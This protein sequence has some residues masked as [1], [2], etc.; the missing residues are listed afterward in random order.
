VWAGNFRQAAIA[1][2]HTKP[3]FP[4]L[5]STVNIETVNR[6]RIHKA[7]SGRQGHWE[8]RLRRGLRA[9]LV[10]TAAFAALM[11][12]LAAQ[13]ADDQNGAAQSGPSAVATVHGMV[14][15]VV[16]GEPLAR[17]LVRIEG[18]ATAGAL[19][20]GDGRYE[21]PGVRVGPQEFEV[22][23]PG[24]LDEDVPAAGVV[25]ENAQGY[26]HNVIVAQGMTDVDFAMTP[27][28]AIRGQIALSTGDP[29][30]GITVTLLKRAVLDGRWNWQ[31]A[32]TTNSNS[33]GVYRFG[34]LAD[35]VYAVF[36]APSMESEPF[37]NVIAAGSA[38]NVIRNGY[39]SVFYPTARD[40]NGAEKIQLAGGEQTEADFL[41]TL[42]AFH[43]VTAM[44][45]LPNGGRSG[46]AAPAGMNFNTVVLDAQGHA[47]PYTS[48]YDAGT[49]T[50]QAFLPDGTYSLQVRVPM[51]QLT[52]SAGGKLRVEVR[53]EGS[54][55]T[56]QADFSVAGRAVT[57]L[58]IPVSPSQGNPI[59][60]SLLRSGTPTAQSGNGMI[61]VYLSD[62]GGWAAGMNATYGQGPVSGPLKTSFMPPG[63]YWAHTAIA[64]H[65]L[66]EGS[67]TA[68]G[69]NLAREPLVV[70]LSGSTAPLTLTLRD[71]C[72][73]LTVRLPAAATETVAG[74]ERSYTVYVIP[75]FDST[76]QVAPRVLRASTGAYATLEGLTPGD[77]HVYTF[78]KPV[79]LAYRDPAT[80]AALANEG[81]AVTLAPGS[82][83]NLVLEIPGQ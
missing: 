57:N 59:Q 64:Q 83:A 1:S 32:A 15:N 82:A 66:C 71:D 50:V 17:A 78:A 53:Q 18:D 42:E 29:A 6:R 52:L 12:A 55:L 34:G 67:F 65:G 80:M 61:F 10:L 40:M 60:V 30:E 31:M 22:V 48:Q 74:E 25:W 70:G 4:S 43:A 39:A 27:L 37:T 24:F 33:D 58:R 28:N 69:A 38:G 3:Q 68:G 23:K 47:L 7:A 77:Y 20:D 56:G 16:S 41:L 81:Q 54:S 26:G 44:V 46:N 62:T 5:S 35:G 19:T 76:G 49:R 75:D 72:A 11:P 63:A 14:R 51:Q 73:S 2:I 79:V 8:A 21:I 36:T 9:C 13:D 45:G